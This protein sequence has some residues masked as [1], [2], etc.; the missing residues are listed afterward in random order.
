MIY[1]L[2]LNPAIDLFIDTDEM[3]P[4][5]VNRT[6]SYDIQANGKGVNVSFILHRLDIENTALGVGG[7]FTNHYI[8]EELQR[9]GIPADFVEIPGTTRINVFTRVRSEQ[10]EYKLVNKGPKVD[11]EY[12]QTLLQKISALLQQDDYLCISGSF[13]QG[14]DPDILTKIAAIVQQNQA[15]LVIDTSYPEVLDTLKFQ[16]ELI[17]PNEVELASW[18]GKS[19]DIT[20]AELVELALVLIKRGAKRVLLSLGAKGALLI[21]EENVLYGNAPTIKVVNTAGSGDTM[22]GTFLGGLATGVSDE[23][24]LKKS[25]AAGS[26]TARSSWITDFTNIQELEDEITVS[27]WEDENHGRN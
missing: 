11:S 18:F 25:I 24:N 22:L 26:D 8:V 20:Q 1:T 3:K 4:D 10:R 17:K 12:Q 7:G 2:T 13:A 6:N 16:P 19:K 14:I 27:S 21:S 5:T 9:N 15:K 23:A